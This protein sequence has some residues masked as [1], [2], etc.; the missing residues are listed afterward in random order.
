MTKP[1]TVIGGD[2]ITDL[3]S[4]LLG[5]PGALLPVL[6]AVQDRFGHVPPA[7]VPRIAKALNLSRAE[8][9]GVIS[10]YHHFRQTPGGR[11]ILRLCRAEACQAV[12][13]DAL[14]AHVR[15]SLAID[16]HE[17]SAD[18]VLT[19]EPAYCLGQCAIGPALL[20]DDDIHA[21]V[22]PDRFDRLIAQLREGAGGAA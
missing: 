7:V 10:Y 13:A 21:R 20:I 2:D 12:G 11:H 16:F 15:H 19:L 1:S 4:P 9:H 8:V 6:H 14:A 18:G 3:L 5:L 17:T 22:T